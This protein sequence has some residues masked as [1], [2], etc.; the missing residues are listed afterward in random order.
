MGDL[1]CNIV[2][3]NTKR[4]YDTAKVRLLLAVEVKNRDQVSKI[5]E[6]LLSVSDV[7]GVKRLM[8]GWSGE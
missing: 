4:K 2:G 1:R 5:R 7:L 8:G 6:I 3:V